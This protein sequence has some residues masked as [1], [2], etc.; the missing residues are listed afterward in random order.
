[1]AQ[2][3]LTELSW[4]SFVPPTMQLFLLAE[5][6]AKEFI[7]NTELIADQL[8]EQTSKTSL[9]LA[10]SAKKLLEEFTYTRRI[11]ELENDHLLEFIHLLSWH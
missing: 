9:Q 2:T 8:D 11:K 4:T 3:I 6:E 1:M 10:E 5:L 7:T